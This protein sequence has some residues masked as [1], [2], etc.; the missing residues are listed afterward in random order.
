MDDLLLCTLR[1]LQL[2]Q[3]VIGGLIGAFEA[4]AGGAFSSWFTWQKERRPRTS[5]AIVSNKFAV[6]AFPAFESGVPN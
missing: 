6:S 5:I 1:G 4:I 2:I 3:T